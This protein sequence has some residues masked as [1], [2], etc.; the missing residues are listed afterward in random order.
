MLLKTE[1]KEDFLKLFYHDIIDCD[2]G[3]QNRLNL[4]ILRISNNRFSYQ[5]L[6]QELFDNIIPF[7]ASVKAAFPMIW[8]VIIPQ[9]AIPRDKAATAAPVPIS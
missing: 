5:E 2:L 6:V 3:N 7:S 8:I 1:I 9:A 4:F